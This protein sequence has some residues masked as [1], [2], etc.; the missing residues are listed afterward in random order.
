MQYSA[1]AEERRQNLLRGLGAAIRAR[2]LEQRGTLKAVA[3]DAKMSERFLVQVELGKGNIS[4]ARLAD[5][6]QVLGATTAELLAEAERTA[7]EAGP[8]LMFGFLVL[9]GLRGAGKTTLGARVAR[10]LR[11]PFIELDQLI[12]ERVGMSLGMIFEMHGE[13]YFHRLQ[14][15]VLA[16]IIRGKDRA[17]IATGGSFVEDPESLQM[18]RHSRVRSVWLKAKPNDHWDRVVA[19]GDARPMKD[20]ADAMA[21][22]RALL[23]RRKSLYAKAEFVIDTSATSL[24]DGVARLVKIGRED[25]K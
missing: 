10:K 19:Q 13:D 17:V 16:E 22:L 8:P 25:R 21:E 3:E 15:E 6:A 11:T 7:G 24:D 1:Y 5:V 2:R 14:R 9:L 12:A 4:V 20:R 23:G 18:L